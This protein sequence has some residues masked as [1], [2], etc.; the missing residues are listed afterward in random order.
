MSCAAPARE[1][2]MAAFRTRHRDLDCLPASEAAAQIIAWTARN[3]S[4]RFW[5][6]VCSPERR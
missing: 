4:A 2:A 3:H 5:K 6:G 1:A